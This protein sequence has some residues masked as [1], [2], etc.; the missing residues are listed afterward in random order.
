MH[1]EHL[2]N[3]HLGWVAGGWVLAAV[4]T[5]GAYVGLVGTGLIPAGDGAVLGLIPAMAAGFFAGG[6][7]VGMRWCD[8]PILHGAAITLVSILVWF[9]GTAALPGEVAVLEGSAPTVLGLVILQLCASVAGAS[10]GRRAT[11]GGDLGR[12]EEE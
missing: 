4:V 8:A 9:A 11:L 2:T 5:G 6:F 7:V 12:K 3:L 1:S 10:T